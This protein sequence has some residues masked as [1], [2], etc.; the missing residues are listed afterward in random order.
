MGVEKVPDWN[1]LL[2]AIIVAAEFFPS[3]QLSGSFHCGGCRLAEEA[4]QP[5]EV[6]RDTFTSAGQPFARD[7]GPT[8]IPDLQAIATKPCTTG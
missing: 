8:V 3:L 2:A 6:L 1:D 5:L 4:H 7:L